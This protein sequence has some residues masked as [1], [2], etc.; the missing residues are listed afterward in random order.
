LCVETIYCESAP[1]T[2]R[3]FGVCTDCTFDEVDISPIL[4]TASGCTFMLSGVSETDVYDII[5]ADAANCEQKIRIEGLS[6]RIVEINETTGYTIHPNLQYKT[7]FNYGIKKGTVVYK[8][9]NQVPLIVWENFR[10]AILNGDIVEILIDD[11]QV[12][13]IL[14]SI[15]PKN[16][17]QIPLSQFVTAFN[18][19]D[20]FDFT[21]DYKRITVTQLECSSSIKKN[22]IN[23][24]FVV[25]PTTKLY[26]YSNIN[27]SLTKV[28]YH[29]T[30]KYPEDLYIA[31]TGTTPTPCCQAPKNFA[32]TSDYLVDQYGFLIEVT[33]VDLNY[34]DRG[35]FYVLD[36]IDTPVFPAPLLP[37]PPTPVAQPKVMLFNGAET[38]TT[39]IIVSYYK[40]RFKC[41]DMKLQQYFINSI[42]D[43]PPTIEELERDACDMADCTPDDCIWDASFIENECI[44]C[45][46]DTEIIV[47]YDM[48]EAED[49]INHACDTAKFNFYAN[50]TLL[51]QVNINNTG[52]DDFFNYPPGEDV[53]TYYPDVNYNRY[54]VIGMSPTQAKEISDLAIDGIVQFRLECVYPSSI[55]NPYPCHEAAAHIQIIRNNEVIYDGYPVGNII[56]INPCSGQIYE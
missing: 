55:N 39:R 32:D 49:N 7:T 27:T 47:S 9:V 40:E 43:T 30:Y 50:D 31:V 45:L 15:T 48:S 54:N 52:V 51:G 38:G 24:E 34:C 5:V 36:Y 25:L 23:N 17:S 42:C 53:N 56:Q 35:I 33:S 29:F 8:E 10:D 20:S 21:F 44:N 26:V 12:D 41:L 2:G 6:P 3:T 28:P 13:D 46:V 16:V 22:I 11:V 19:N 1:I 37:V 14:Y 4:T 18:N